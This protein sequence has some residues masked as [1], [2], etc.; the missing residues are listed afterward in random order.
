MP[1]S[2]VDVSHALAKVLNGTRVVSTAIN[3][4]GPV[5]AHRLA[6]L[7]AEVIKIEPPT[8]DPLASMA[9]IWYDELRQGQQVVRLDLKS[10][11]GRASLHE[12]LAGARVLITS[13][14]PSALDRVGLGD[15]DER[16]PHLLHVE[17]VGDT[18]DPDDAGHDLTYEALA[19]LVEPPQLPQVPLADLLGA[20]QAIT[21]TLGGLLGGLTGPLRVGLGDAVRG[22]NASVRS[23]LTGPGSLLGGATWRYDLYATADGWVALAA[24]E[25]HF[26]PR[27]L[28]ML[29]LDAEPADRSPVEDAFAARTT[30]EWMRAAKELDVPL[31]PVQQPSSR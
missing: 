7:G 20:E 24:L 27:T 13:I 11:E 5:T 4:P 1:Q 15:L 16:H 8:G 23:G 28:T 29:G 21:A 31:A 3:L 6:A 9:P 25:P 10:D 26:I 12:F 18:T 19:G 2:T 14:R 22:V 30:Q 17:I